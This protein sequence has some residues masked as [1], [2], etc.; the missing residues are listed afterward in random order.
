M[1]RFDASPDIGGFAINLGNGEGFPIGLVV[2]FCDGSF[3]VSSSFIDGSFV[4]I[5]GNRCTVDCDPEGPAVVAILGIAYAVCDGVF[6][7]FTGEKVGDFR[8]RIVEFIGVI[9]IA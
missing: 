8:I 9:A 2:I 4:V 3:D 7:G 6:E 5:D 1:V